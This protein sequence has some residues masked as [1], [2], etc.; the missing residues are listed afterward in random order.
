[1][2]NIHEV[3]DTTFTSAQSSKSFSRNSSY[4][5]DVPMYR[6]VQRIGE[7]KLQEN[8]HVKR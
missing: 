7:Y 1:M 4:S 5:S 6:E 3:K 2:E 8:L